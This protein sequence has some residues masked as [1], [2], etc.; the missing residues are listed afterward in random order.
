M[1]EP[2]F[3]YDWDAIHETIYK[4]QPN[5]VAAVSGRDVRWVGNEGGI[6]RPSEWSVIV[7]G[8]LTEKYQTKADQG[9][10]METSYDAKDKGSRKTIE[11][12][13]KK[14]KEVKFAFKPAESDVKIRDGWFWHANQTPKSVDEL[15]RLYYTNVGWNSSFLLNVGAN[16]NGLIDESDA[17]ALI[18]MGD[19]IKADASKQIAVKG[20]RVG[21]SEASMKADENIRNILVDE[22]FNTNAALSYDNYRMPNDAHI[23]EF[24]FD[25]KKKIKRIDLREDLRYSQR[26]ESI[27][28]WAKKKNGKWKLIADNTIV[29]NRKIFMFKNPTETDTVRVVVRQS[30][31]NPYFRFIGF[32]E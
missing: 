5:C 1:L 8:E 21:G 16:T 26:V 24:S 6:V 20:V 22:K 15:V 11:S 27:E 7:Q 4:Y 14:S 17:T 19:R 31:S 18:G 30:R 32:Y 2:G 10:K 3:E 12:F 13:A 9:K 28:I 25:A 29:G 23:M